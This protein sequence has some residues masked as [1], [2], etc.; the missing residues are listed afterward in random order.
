MEPV[1]VFPLPEYSTRITPFD[2]GGPNDSLSRIHAKYPHV[3][4]RLR[5]LQ[6]SSGSHSAFSTCLSLNR[7]HKLD[8]QSDSNVQ[9]LKMPVRKDG[10]NSNRNNDLTNGN[11]LDEKHAS[12]VE[13]CTSRPK[14]L[15]RGQPFSISDLLVQ[16]PPAKGLSRIFA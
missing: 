4:N 10:V 7:I 8:R 1:S 15:T 6:S 9:R 12:N 2:P 5:A 11:S 14:Y 3:F 13:H 16:N